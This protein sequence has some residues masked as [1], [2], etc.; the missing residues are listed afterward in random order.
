MK[1]IYTSSYF[2]I[3]NIFLNENIDIIFTIFQLNK[4]SS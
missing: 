3:K 1:Y 2:K 4:V